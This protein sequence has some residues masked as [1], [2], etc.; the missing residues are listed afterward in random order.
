ML[1]PLDEEPL[2]DL[3]GSELWGILGIAGFTVI[4]YL[5]FLLNWEIVL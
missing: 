4:V 5:L 1:D 2:S 3:D